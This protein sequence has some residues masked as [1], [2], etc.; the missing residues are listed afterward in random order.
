VIALEFSTRIPW[1]LDELY[2]PSFEKQMEKAE[3]RLIAKEPTTCQHL[4][5]WAPADV[6]PNQPPSFV[7]IGGGSR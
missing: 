5:S 7:P 3:E 2:D 4:I 6:E 1:V